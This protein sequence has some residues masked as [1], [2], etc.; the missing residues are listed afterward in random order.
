VLLADWGGEEVEL[1]DADR[2]QLATLGKIAAMTVSARLEE[3][4]DT[5]LPRLLEIAR[6]I[7]ENVMPQLASIAVGLAGDGEIDPAARNLYAYAAGD[8]TAELREIVRKLPFGSNGSRHSQQALAPGVTRVFR[9]VPVSSS[10]TFELD[11]PQHAKPLVDHFLTEVLQNTTK[12]AH[13]SNVDVKVERK[14]GA[15]S[16]EVTND[17]VIDSEP[18]GRAGL[19]L[20]ALHALQQGA[21]L[22]FGTPAPRTWR[23]RLVI[24]CEDGVAQ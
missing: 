5:E 20:I 18:G 8:A 16:I 12:H 9:G 4:A 19:R 13:P 14:N 10:R 17:G 21:V 23:A 24:P 1:S 6:R 2:A 7:H 22:G 15:I 11:V 3:Q